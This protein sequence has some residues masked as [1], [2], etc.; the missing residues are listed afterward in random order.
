MNINYGNKTGR[1]VQN[2]ESGTVSRY[3][4]QNYPFDTEYSMREFLEDLWME[5][6]EQM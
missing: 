5:Q 4:E 6:R 2:S 1:T 3:K